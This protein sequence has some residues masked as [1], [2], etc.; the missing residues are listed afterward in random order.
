MPEQTY[1]VIVIGSGAGGLTAALA[2]AQAGKKV[3]VIEQHEVPGG[4]CHSFTLEGYRFSPG[5]HYIG[6]VQPGGQLANVYRGLGVSKHMTFCEINP[7]GFDHIFIGEERF[8]IPKGRDKFI[9]RLVERFPHE[10][11]GIRRYMDTVTEIMLSTRRIRPPKSLRGAMRSAK[12]VFTLLKWGL[13]TGAGLINSHVKDPILRAIL[14]GQ[15]GDHGLPP[16]QVSAGVHAGIVQHYF[17]GGYYPLGG[18]FTIPRAFVRELKAA[19]GEILL[20]SRVHEIIIEN[21]RARGIILEDGRVIRAGTIVSNADP[22][23]T[24]GGMVGRAH[25][26]SRLKRKLDRVSYS[27][28]SLSL[29]LAVDMDLK[30]AGFDSGNYWFYDHDDLDTIYAEGFRIEHLEVRTPPAM[31]MTVTTL[32]DPSKMHNRHH[33][34]EVFA[35]SSFDDFKLWEGQPSG[36]RAP[37]YPALKSQIANAILA[38]LEKRVPGISKFVVFCDLGTP[39]TNR[40]YLE[41]TKGNLYGIAKNRW[42]VGP[43]AFPVKTEIDGLFMC[44]ASTVSH[45]VAGATGSGLAAARAILNCSTADLFTQKGPEIEILPSEDTSQWPVNLQ[46]KIARGQGIIP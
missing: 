40:H 25:L 37:D 12:A 9:Q 2:L 7:E 1:D 32:K 34:L 42:Q 43:G 10:E 14:A 13:R 29:F 6:G 4:W 30:A 11:N 18:A 41:A 26:S 20:S 44:G 19:G 38:G 31:F 16:S 45:G 5:V 33:T 28:S 39:L 46:E 22:E 17:N 36:D 3:L 24:F 23:V 35:F 15:S 27:V 8:D 21:K